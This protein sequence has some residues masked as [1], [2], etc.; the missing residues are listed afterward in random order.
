MLVSHGADTAALREVSRALGQQ[1]E[2]IADVA[3][4]GSAMLTLLMDSWSGPDV[5]QF[6][7]GW[8]QVETA[9]SGAAERLRAFAKLA[10]QQADEQ[11]G[12]SG[13]SSGGGGGATP[14]GGPGPGVSPVAAET[15][16]QRD[17]QEPGDR[18]RE[19]P[20]DARSGNENR[21]D[22]DEWHGRKR[23]PE[24]LPGEERPDAG[25][26]LGEP[27]PGTSLDDEPEP[28]P[29]TPVDGGAGEHDSE[30]AGPVDHATHRAARV[31]A[32]LKADDWP[33]ASQNLDHFLDNGGEPL[34]QDVDQMLEDVPGLDTQAASQRQ[35]LAADAVADARSRGI[36]GPVTYPVSTP[37]DSYYRP[38]RER[39][40]VLC[41]GW[42]GVQPDGVRHRLPAERA[43]WALPLRDGHDRHLPGS[44]QL[45]RIQGDR[46]RAA[47]GQRR[48]AGGA[49]S[50]GHR[51]GVRDVR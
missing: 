22:R 50:G 18:G 7:S 45:G 37:W 32:D 10:L 5:E 47:H 30:F 8:Q 44:V 48:A 46:D 49:A 4:R 20:G 33:N 17:R 29:W 14:T 27:V 41:H 2:L 1:A 3:P 9:T 34:E 11:D 36:T 38:V 39:R 25:P 19:A 16:G 35:D 15:S 31:G 26:A 42:H 6:G 21:P 24:G 43:R 28:P 13:E 23:T 40:L 51:Q 12:A